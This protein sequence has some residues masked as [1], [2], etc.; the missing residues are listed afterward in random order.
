MVVQQPQK[1][2]EVPGQGPRIHS[3]A[4]RLTI[5]EDR[6]LTQGSS[7]I[8]VV[9]DRLPCIRGQAN[10]TRGHEHKQRGA[11]SY[12]QAKSLTNA[13]N[14]RAAENTRASASTRA[15]GWLHRRRADGLDRTGESDWPLRVIDV[16]D[17]TKLRVLGEGR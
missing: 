6:H 16:S 4:R 15:R 17:P 2:S 10:R 8:A 12:W 1:L 11:A 7:Q 13:G 9:C 14:R 5:L 3:S